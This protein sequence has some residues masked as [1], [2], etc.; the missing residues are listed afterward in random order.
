[1]IPPNGGAPTTGTLALDGD[2]LVVTF[3]YYQPGVG[4]YAP[5]HVAIYHRNSAGAWTSPVTLDSMAQYEDTPGGP[6]GLV[7]ARTDRFGNDLDVRDQGA[8]AHVFIA[9]PGVR[10]PSSPPAGPHFVDGAVFSVQVSSRG[11][12]RLPAADLPTAVDDS[13]PPVATTLW[14]SLWEQLGPQRCG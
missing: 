7:G 6:G 12:G 5:G 14:R 8:T 11:R 9:D 1:M 10:P 13:S 3:H 2:Y 4:Y